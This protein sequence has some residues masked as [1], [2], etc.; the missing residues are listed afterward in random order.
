M[1]KLI[2]LIICFLFFGINNNIDAQ[3]R[4]VLYQNDSV[5]IIHD[6]YEGVPKRGIYLYPSTSLYYIIDKGNIDTFGLAYSH[7]IGKTYFQNNMFSI[8]HQSIG[9]KQSLNYSL[10]KKI[11]NKWKLI[12][13]YSGVAPNQLSSYQL[14]QIDI[15][16]LKEH[17]H[18]NGD[19]NFSSEIKVDVEKKIL[20]RYKL[21][22]N[23][24]REIPEEYPFPNYRN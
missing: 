24:S 1:K 14:E 10:V 15:F 13:Y 17:L 5:K 21:Q 18:S 20:F 3:K 4:T 8:F 6:F 7:P 9:G 22:K 2:Y 23:G 19:E 11:G 12:T 16:T